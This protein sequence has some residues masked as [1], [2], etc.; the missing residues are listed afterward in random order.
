MASAPAIFE[1]LEDRK[2]FSTSVSEWNSVALD[3]IRADRTPPTSED[4][5]LEAYASGEVNLTETGFILL[6]Q[7]VAK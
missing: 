4:E 2:L 7:V 1:S 6:C 3:A 5:V